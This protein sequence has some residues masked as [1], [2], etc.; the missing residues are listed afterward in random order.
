MVLIGH[1]RERLDCK[2]WSRVSALLVGTID[3]ISCS[4]EKPSKDLG[5]ELLGYCRERADC[6]MWSRDPA[7]LV[8]TIDHI[9]CKLR[10]LSGKLKK[11]GVHNTGNYAMAHQQ[12]GIVCTTSAQVRFVNGIGLQYW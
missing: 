2:M 11:T 7:L 6:M 1:R 12:H 9:H 4:P 3:H 10:R 5:T 8:G